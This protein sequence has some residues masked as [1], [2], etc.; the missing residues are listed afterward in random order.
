M[1]DQQDT[2]AAVD[3]TPKEERFI[4]KLIIQTTFPAPPTR[5]EVSL[6]GTATIKYVNL[7]YF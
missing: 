5:L 3:E 2:K 4:I 6:P 1:S 7:N